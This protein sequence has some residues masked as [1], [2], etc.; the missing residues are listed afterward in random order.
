MSETAD[1]PVWTL[2]CGRWRAE[3]FDPR[4]DPAALG[5][6][7]VHGGYVRALWRGDCLLTARAS[8]QWDP[9]VGQGLPDVF[10]K[11]LS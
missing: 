10:E 7:Y 9:Y 3:V 8:E 11:R 1:L 4:P 5:A 2:E 6:R